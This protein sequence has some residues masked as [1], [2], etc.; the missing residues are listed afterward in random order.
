VNLHEAIIETLQEHGR[1]MTTREIAAALNDSKRYTKKDGSLI[2]DFQVH[3]RTANYPH[4]FRREGSTVSLTD[5]G[6]A[7][8]RCED[9]SEPE[10]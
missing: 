10:D 5:E 8:V 3:G 9:L 2:S 7:N 6:A 1:D 4:L